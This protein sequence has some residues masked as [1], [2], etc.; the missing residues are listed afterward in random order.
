MSSSTC[1]T[2]FTQYTQL[3]PPVRELNGQGSGGPSLTNLAPCD[4]WICNTDAYEYE[5]IGIKYDINPPPPAGGGVVTAARYSTL[6]ELKDAWADGGCV[7]LF[8][9]MVIGYGTTSDDTFSPL[10]FR[11][12]Q[13]DFSF[14]FSRY[15]NQDP[16]TGLT[17]PVG[18]TTNIPLVP[19]ANAPVYPSIYPN[20][21]IGGNYTL[22]VPG[23]AGYDS[24]ID[25]LL[26]ACRQIPGACQPV[27]EL[28]CGQCNRNQILQTKALSDFCGCVAP[29]STSDQ[30]Y[31][32]TINTLSPSCD[33]LCNK[34]STVKLV[35][36][37]TGYLQ[38][39]NANV[40]VIDNVVINA[41]DTQG[42]APTFTQVC[43]SCVDGGN[44]LCIIDATFENTVTSI[45]G[46]DSLPINTPA[47]FLQYCP[48]SQC[49]VN[50]PQ[51]G[52]FN[53]I[54]CTQT[55]SKKL[56]ER[57]GA[58]GPPIKFPWYLFIVFGVILLIA[59][60]VII[61]YKYQTDNVKV[62]EYFPGRK[63]KSAW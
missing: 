40:C 54:E 4:T 52:T 2:Y 16:T 55:L 27:Q 1:I 7:N 58:E 50:D 31:N 11:Y 41:V 43:P 36:P 38:Q 60:L 62:Y 59:I 21:W 15:F 47:K 12:V 49:Y 5:C 48:G 34:G 29:S 25:T 9:S 42:A 45:R 61:S 56:L 51:T 44:C 63:Y 30:Y 6:K 17:G 22:A 35:D 13:D 19:S 33:P 53:P 24:F 28:M 57:S 37:N 39:C 8:K 26:D 20:T 3:E 23:E 18:K 10:G 32:E 14:L 46:N